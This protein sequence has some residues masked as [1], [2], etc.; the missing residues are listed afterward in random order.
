MPRRAASRGGCVLARHQLILAPAFGCTRGGRRPRERPGAVVPPDRLPS[1]PFGDLLGNADSVRW[2]RDALGAGRLGHALLLTG[3]DQVGKTTLLLA[4]AG[5][6]LPAGTWPGDLTTHPDLWLEDGDGERIGIE[7]MRAGREPG[8][9][10]EFL[11]LRAYAGG[12]RAA[13]IARAERLTEPAANS[14]LKTV[15]EP[16]PGSHILLTAENPE[17]LPDTIVSRCQRLS[18]GPVPPDAIEGWLRDRHGISEVTAALAVELSAGRP[19]RALRLAGDPAALSAELA[20][21]DRFLAAGGGG[22]PAALSAAAELAPGPG[23][24]GRRRLLL[25]LAVWA[26]FV[27]DAALHAAGA[28]EM[29]RWRS[30]SAALERWSETLPLDRSSVILDSLLKASSDAAANAHP[31]LLLEALFLDI[32]GGSP[33]PPR[34]T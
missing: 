18:L 6:L 10:Q 4:V 15:E 16:P 27:R 7:R 29:A 26:S 1:V 32:F 8:S 20:S 5:E 31:R 13:I 22:T 12:A 17:R 33:S 2:I 3:P 19:G 34:T 30:R 9:L 14:L 24:E 11:S 23:A 25:N 28:P 21:L